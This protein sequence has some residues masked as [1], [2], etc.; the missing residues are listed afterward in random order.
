MN[1]ADSVV[2]GS[3]SKSFTALAVMQLVEAGTVDLDTEL[4]QYLDGFSG[5]RTSPTK[6]TESIWTSARLTASSSFDPA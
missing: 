4:S 1:P 5:R 3:I 2:A 6:P